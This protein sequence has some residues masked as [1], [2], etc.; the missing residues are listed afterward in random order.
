MITLTKPKLATRAVCAVCGKPMTAQ[1]ER[2]QAL[3]N[4]HPCDG[5]C[6]RRAA[7]RYR[8]RPEPVVIGGHDV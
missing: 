8:S 5:G 4:Q 2:E 3:M 7:S 1:N 6:T